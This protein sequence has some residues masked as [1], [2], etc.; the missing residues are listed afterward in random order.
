M[1]RHGCCKYPG[2]HGMAKQ[3][4]AV[5]LSHLSLQRF[6]AWAGGGTGLY[7]MRARERY[8]PEPVQSALP[9]AY[10]KAAV[11]YAARKLAKELKAYVGRGVV[12]R[13]LIA[14]FLRLCRLRAPPA[15][16]S[17]AAAAWAHSST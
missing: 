15:L 12:L 8:V 14:N 5:E 2:L 6:A 13:R 4:V 10:G 1:Q 16:R 3:T 17:A 11:A 9:Q 7:G